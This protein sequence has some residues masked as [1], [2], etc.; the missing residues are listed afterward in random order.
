VFQSAGLWMKALL[1]AVAKDPEQGEV[2][3]R[4]VQEESELLVLWALV[5][6]RPVVSS[7]VVAKV[8]ASLDQFGEGGD[9]RGSKRPEESTGEGSED[10]RKQVR[11]G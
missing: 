3:M 1:D 10:R 6:P 2:F 5:L 4:E 8:E 9:L 11:V 7:V